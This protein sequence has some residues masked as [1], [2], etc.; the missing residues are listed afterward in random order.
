[1][2]RLVRQMLYVKKRVGVD[3]VGLGL[4]YVFDQNE[5]ATHVRSNPALYPKDLDTGDTLA[6]VAPEDIETIVDGLTRFGLSDDEVSKVMCANWMRIA[7]EVW[8]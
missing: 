4:D 7:H 2:E 6:M 5:L 3:H 8:R 1:V